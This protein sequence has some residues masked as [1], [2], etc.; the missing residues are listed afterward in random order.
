MAEVPTMAITGLTAALVRGIDQAE[1]ALELEVDLRKRQ[2][3]AAME[4]VRQSGSCSRCARR[5]GGDRRHS[6]RLSRSS[7]LNHRR[8]ASHAL[9]P[10]RF[11]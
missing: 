8:V 2:F 9:W 5:R 11:T 7:T 6:H 10:E 3:E 4:E 1:Q